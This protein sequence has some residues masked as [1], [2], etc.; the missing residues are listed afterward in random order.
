MAGARRAA[1]QAHV[2]EGELLL[3]L[4]QGGHHPL[5]GVAE[6]G[7]ALEAAGVDRVGPGLVAVGG[8]VAVAVEL[9]GDGRGEL[10][11]PG[12]LGVVADPQVH[13]DHHR[14]A[15]ARPAGTLQGL[16]QHR[17]GLGRLLPAVVGQGEP[18]VGQPG[19]PVQRLGG[20]PAEVQGRAAR[21][22]RAGADGQ[23][24]A[25]GTVGGHPLGQRPAQHGQLLLQ[26]PAAAGAVDPEGVE[27][28]FHP[29]A[30]QPQHQPAT[31]DQVDHPGLLGDLPGPVQ[32]EQQHARPQPDAR[33][34]GG[35]GGQERE[36]LG[37]V[38]VLDGVVLA[39]PD[40]GQPELLGQ[41]RLLEALGVEGRVGLA[42]GAGSQ[43]GPGAEGRGAWHALDP[44]PRAPGPDQSPIL[45]APNQGHANRDRPGGRLPATRIPCPAWSGRGS[46]GCWPAGPPSGWPSWWPGSSARRRPPSSRWAGRPSTPP[47]SGSRSSPSGPSA[48]ATSS[49]CWPGSPRS[50]PGSRSPSASWPPAAPAWVWPAWPCSAPSAPPPPSP[51]RAPPPSTP[52]RPWPAPWRE[53]WPSPALDP[54]GPGAPQTDPEG[55]ARRGALRAV[56]D[57]G[58]GGPAA[59]SG[60]RGGGGWGGRG[61]RGRG[62]GAGAAVGRRR[63]PGRGRHP[64]PASAAGPLAEGAAI[65]LPGLSS[66]YTPNRDF[67]RVDT[68]LVVPRIAAEDWRLR[69]HGRVERELAL[70]FGQLLARPLIERDITLSCVSNEVGGRYVGTARWVGVPLADL[71]GRPGCEPGPTSS[72][73]GR[74]TGSPSAPRPPPCSTAA[75]PCWP[76]P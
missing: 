20:G 39:A 34:P 3:E 35:D 15:V 62:A 65:E 11:R 52:S 28:A 58:R 23:V 61:R 32:G 57:R 51:A 4:G 25:A 26:Q 69:V 24:G 66:F 12:A 22:G 59:V 10:G 13:A 5:G 68:A 45:A 70:D 76:W 54:R 74:P 27:L 18:A 2:G 1:P 60:H 36:L 47:R 6:H 48:S 55:D 9:V 41:D 31:G 29:A 73:P 42:P 37:E 49:S 7:R 8:P 71:L 46:P 64:G 40:G 75:T 72:C 56:H 33:G 14:E 67:Y 30:A 16:G 38:A 21:L 43:L 63:L 19:H 17:P 53:P 44:T 50:W